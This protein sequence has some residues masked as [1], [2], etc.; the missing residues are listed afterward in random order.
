[1]R[2]PDFKSSDEQISGATLVRQLA[3]HFL[4]QCL[5]LGG[6]HLMMMAVD[7]AWAISSVHVDAGLSDH[8]S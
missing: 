2:R 7:S 5:P 1:M 3:R 4:I 6:H 8:C